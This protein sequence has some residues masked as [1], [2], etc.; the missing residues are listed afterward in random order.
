[1]L[2]VAWWDVL[3]ANPRSWLPELLIPVVTLVIVSALTLLWVRH[4]LGIYARKGPRRGLPDPD[5]A[6]STDRLGRQLHFEYGVENAP[7][8]RLDL[9]GPTKRY[10]VE[11]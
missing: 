9:T 6:W 7:V 3:R 1:M 4:N 10:R 11:W 8:V 5:A 2:A